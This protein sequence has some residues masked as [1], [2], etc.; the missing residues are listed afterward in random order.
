MAHQAEILA[1]NG[2]APVGK[3]VVYHSQGSSDRITFFDRPLNELPN[4]GDKTAAL[5]T[6]VAGGNSVRDLLFY[7]PNDF[8][9]R[10]TKRLLVDMVPGEVCAFL[11]RIVSHEQPASPG[12]PTIVR[13]CDRSAYA[14]IP[15]FQKPLLAK[16]PVGQDFVISGVASRYNGTIQFG[17][18]DHVIPAARRDELPWIEPIWGLTKG[19]PGSV[20]RRVIQNTV[21]TMPCVPEWQ[22]GRL[23]EKE[24]WPSFDCSLK[25]LLCPSIPPPVSCRR[26]LAYDELFGRQVRMLWQQKKEAQRGGR[27]LTGDTQLRRDALARFGFPL[28]PSQRQAVG[29]IFSDMKAPAP[30]R[31]LVQGDVGAGKTIIAVL[32]MLLAVEAKAQAAL[33]VPTELLASQHYRTIQK[34]SPLPVALLTG[35]MPVAAKR[36]VLAGLATGQIKMVVGTHALLQDNVVFHDL[37]LAVIDEQ[38]RFG[39]SQRE[40]FIRKGPLADL[41]LMTATPIPR[42]LVLTQFGG[43]SVTKLEGKPAGRKSIKTT[44]HPLDMMV[45]VY[46]A[47][48]RMIRGGGRVYWVCP[49][50]DGDIAIDLAAATER[51][52]DLV[53]HFPRR[54][55]LAHGGQSQADRSAALSQFSAGNVDILVSTTVVEVGVDV[56][57]AN[58]MVIEQAERF[59]VAQLHQLRGRVGRGDAQSYCLLLHPNRLSEVAEKRLKL[60]RDTNDGFIIAEADLSLR[61]GGD[62]LGT[63]Q[64]GVPELRLANVETDSDLV[65]AAHYEALT[66]LTEDPD[67]SSARGLA[68]RDLIYMLWGV[69]LS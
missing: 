47:L 49:A 20:L 2:D 21:K 65:Q 44:T 51:F 34:I 45:D 53:R 42:T 61:G 18:V 16:Y 30:M 62:L 52:D 37:G 22:S 58:V 55:A 29:E 8:V 7:M 15:V 4:I 19:L 3:V 59:G 36:T 12:R 14:E 54:V 41:L 26:R 6:K 32:A 23:L 1:P 66:L 31:R 46:S 39:V 35:D 69:C 40:A 64:S 13:I 48:K 60:L 67:L 24:K 50:V 57:A 10:R 25:S 63:A 9:D 68:S 11:I 28:T 33:L 56:P 43:L 5:L 17:R 38:H 27:A